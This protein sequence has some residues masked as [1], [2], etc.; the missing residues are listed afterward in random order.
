M[1]DNDSFGIG[2]TSEVEDSVG[3]SGYSDFHT[4]GA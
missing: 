1:E 4:I 2:A 3:F